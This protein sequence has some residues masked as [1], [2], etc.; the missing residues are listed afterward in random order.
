MA[1][2]EEDLRVKRTRKLITQAF[3]ALLR[4]KKFNQISIQEIA[5]DAMINRAT[6]YAHY[7][8]KDDLYDSLIENFFSDLIGVLDD[9]GQGVASG[10]SLNVKKVEELLTRFY[11]F[12]RE[13]PEIA[14][15]IID[16]AQDDGLKT[17]LTDILYDRYESL[18]EHLEVRD[19]DLVVPNDFVINY[20]ISILTG[21]LKWWTTSGGSLSSSEFAKLIIKLISSGHLAVLGVDVKWEG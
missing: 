12:V 18:F 17:K 3:I 19:A 11:D 9:E 6:F 14:Q 4:R 2:K 21:T 8:G 16:K 13:N 10:Q 15:M 1:K 5:D 7:A 20:I